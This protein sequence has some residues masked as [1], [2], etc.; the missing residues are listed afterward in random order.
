MEH[1][2]LEQFV[3][4]SLSKGSCSQ[5]WMKNYAHVKGEKRSGGGMRCL[6]VQS[7]RIVMMKE[8]HVGLVA[9]VYV[10]GVRERC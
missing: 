10:Y 1:Y 4:F 9:G 2:V 3:D 8:G 5:W 7:S 6:T